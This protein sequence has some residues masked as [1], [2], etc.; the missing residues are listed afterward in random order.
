M[1]IK[2]LSINDLNDLLV[3]KK[4]DIK[5]ELRNRKSQTSPTAE[6]QAGD[7]LKHI[8]E[9]GDI[10]IV[11]INNIDEGN[12]HY[13][14]LFISK[15]SNDIT[16]QEYD[17]YINKFENYSKLDKTTYD[18]IVEDCHKLNRDVEELYKVYI[19]KFSYIL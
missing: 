15:E 13:T 9:N 11:Y 17:D 2:Q 16:Y 3:I 10:S 19:N 8:D 7:Y 18:Y 6:I 4:S 1:D 12:V 5:E 14:M